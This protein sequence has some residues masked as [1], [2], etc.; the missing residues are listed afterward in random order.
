MSCVFVH[1]RFYFPNFK[2]SQGPDDLLLLLCSDMENID[3][4]VLFFT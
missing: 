2:T 4:D 3:L 1:L